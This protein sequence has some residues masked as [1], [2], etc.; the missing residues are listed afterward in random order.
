MNVLFFVSLLKNVRYHHRQYIFA[1]S[2]DKNTKIIQVLY[3][4]QSCK[5]DKKKK[6]KKKNLLP[7][8]SYI[9]LSKIYISFYSFSPLKAIPYGG[10]NPYCLKIVKCT[11]NYIPFGI[12]I[13][14]RKREI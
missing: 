8:F 12:V 10:S 7:K 11:S 6:K 5:G 3:H 9:K 14:W 1:Q 13:L 2:N 4:F